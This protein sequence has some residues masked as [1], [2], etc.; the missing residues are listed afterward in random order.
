[1]LEVSMFSEGFLTHNCWACA[2][3]IVYL[4]LFKIFTYL[5][6]LAALQWVWHRAGCCLLLHSEHKQYGHPGHLITVSISTHI[7]PNLHISTHQLPTSGVHHSINHIITKLYDNARLHE[8]IMT[9]EAVIQLIGWLGTP[10]FGPLDTVPRLAP[11]FGVQLQ[12]H[13]YFPIRSWRVYKG[14]YLYS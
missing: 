5:H 12:A 9:S 4:P 8:I 7:Y 6:I 2:S 1:M 13:A 3:V 14:W 11:V 10:P